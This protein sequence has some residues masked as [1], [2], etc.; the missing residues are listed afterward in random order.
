M[1][2]NPES[3][4]AKKWLVQHGLLSQEE[5]EDWLRENQPNKLKPKKSPDGMFKSSRVASQWTPKAEGVTKKRRKADL[6]PV[7]I[8]K[9]TNPQKGSS[10]EQKKT[11]TTGV[12]GRKII[13]RP[14]MTEKVRRVLD[15][16]PEAQKGKLKLKGSELSKLGLFDGGLDSSDD[17]DIPLAKRLVRK[18]SSDDDD[19]PLAKR[20]FHA[21]VDE[22]SSDKDVPLAKRRASKD[23]SEDDDVPLAER[24]LHARADEL[25]SDDDVPLAKRRALKKE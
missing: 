17:D 6:S 2:E 5:A 15:K 18:D 13:E 12:S 8:K 22:P 7:P 19:V 25:S 1:K 21:R 9:L 23:S 16:V 20:R 3:A 24:T 10:S 4:L 14:K 11:K